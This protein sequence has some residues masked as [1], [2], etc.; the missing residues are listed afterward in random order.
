[1]KQM[2]SWTKDNNIIFSYLIIHNWEK[3]T[4]LIWCSHCRMNIAS[5]QL[6]FQHIWMS[7]SCWTSWATVHP[8]KHVQQTG[9]SLSTCTQ[10]RWDGQPLLLR[11]FTAILPQIM[12]TMCSFKIDVSLSALLKSS[13]ID[14]SG[15]NDYFNT[16]LYFLHVRYVFVCFTCIIFC[17]LLM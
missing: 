2:Y 17:N 16:F 3:S 7:S 13:I 14:Y 5:R 12:N 6:P 1:M 8:H 4:I 11:H 9:K 15:H 10:L